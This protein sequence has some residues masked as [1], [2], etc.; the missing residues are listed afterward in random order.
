M[1]KIAIVSAV[2]LLVLSVQFCG[3]RIY[4]DPIFMEKTREH[5]IIAVLPFEMVFTGKKPK[6]LSVQQVR[7]IEEVESIA[8]QNSFYNSLL[9]Q[10]HRHR[11]PVRIDIQPTRQTNRILE[12]HEIGIRES[13]D[14][15]SREL[16][17]ILRVDAVVRTRIEKRRF[18]SGLAS[19]GL[20]VGTD[21]LNALLADTPLMIF[22]P[23]STNRIKA[24][25]YVCSG[26]DGAV[27]WS[28]DVVDETDWRMSAEDIID[29]VNFHFAKKFPYR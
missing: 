6:K 18:M 23:T 19:F 14:M 4:T 8:F 24:G 10:T 27:L 16:A 7:K 1:R 21:I 13:W 11:N 25:C 26:S 2:L 15:E 28:L 20:E 5:R 9:H 17:R 12:R 29:G 3:G 22:L